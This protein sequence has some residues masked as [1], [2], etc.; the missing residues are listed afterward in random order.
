MLKPV[1]DRIRAVA[2][3]MEDA[4]THQITDSIPDTVK[5]K[6]EEQLELFTVNIETM[7]N[8]VEHITEAA[9]KNCR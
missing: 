5:A 7:C 3:L 9:K 1:T 4:Y 2:F 8:T 6:I